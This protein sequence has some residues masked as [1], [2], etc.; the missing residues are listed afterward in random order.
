LAFIR[1]HHPHWRG[2]NK[3]NEWNFV[4]SSEVASADTYVDFMRAITQTAGE[5]GIPYFAIWVTLGPGGSALTFAHGHPILLPLQQPVEV[6]DVTGAGDTS[7]AVMAAVLCE[8]G[9]RDDSVEVGARLAN[10]AGSVAV[11]RRGCW[12]ANWDEIIKAIRIEEGTV[13][14]LLTPQA[15][16]CAGREKS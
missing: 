6:R 3:L 1:Q 15:L 12:H 5:A 7:I 13:V 14:D 10:V 8:A 4:D 16:R 11:Q 2:V 9:M